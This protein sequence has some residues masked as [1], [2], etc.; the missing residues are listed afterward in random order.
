MNYDFYFIS[1]V[2][3]SAFLHGLEES[4]LQYCIVYE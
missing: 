4:V 2:Y 3:V 1:N